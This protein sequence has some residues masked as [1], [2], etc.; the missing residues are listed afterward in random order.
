[1][2]SKIFTPKTMHLTNPQYR[3]LQSPTGGKVLDDI[4]YDYNYMIY[5]GFD[6]W[7]FNLKLYCEEGV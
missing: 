1:M 3:F 5:F 2:L 4:E 7:N 6:R